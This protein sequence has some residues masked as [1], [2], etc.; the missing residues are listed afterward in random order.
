MKG[1]CGHSGLALWCQM[2]TKHMMCTPCGHRSIKEQCYAVL[3]TVYDIVLC[4][5]CKMLSD[6]AR[7]LLCVFLPAPALAALQA[8]TGSPPDVSSRLLD[9]CDVVDACEG[10][11]ID[12]V[13]AAAERELKLSAS[14]G[15]YRPPGLEFMIH[16]L[17]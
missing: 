1:L 15:E 9:L 3:C 11:S 13:I 10:L 17:H 6:G 16:R 4:S 7:H 2:R 5:H 8:P 14:P 12:T